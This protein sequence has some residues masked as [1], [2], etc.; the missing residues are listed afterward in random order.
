MTAW[1]FVMGVLFGIVVSCQS[2]RIHL[3]GD[4]GGLNNNL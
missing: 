1:D 3:L 2:I 4:S